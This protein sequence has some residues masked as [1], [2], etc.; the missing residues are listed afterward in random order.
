MSLLKEI[1]ESTRARVEETKQ[2]VTESVL[3]ERI[4]GAPAP[5]GFESA[6]SGPGVSVIAEIKRASPAK[7][8]LNLTL[9]A[10]EMARA[11]E[12]GGA[13]AISVLTEP[14]YFKGS[15]EDL[16]A[17]VA[18]TDLPVLRKDFVIDEY[19]LLE[20]RA[21]GCRRGSFDRPHIGR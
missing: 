18:A 7:G 21:A 10:A 3:E 15:L 13:A 14:S 6:L 8:D 16:E 9:N 2:K 4:A 5:R 11:Y 19:Q 12:R 20:A 17:V 1:C